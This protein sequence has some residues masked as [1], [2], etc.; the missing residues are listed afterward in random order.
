[1]GFGEVFRKAY[2]QGVSY[3]AFLKADRDRL[4]GRVPGYLLDL[5]ESDGWAGYRD[6]LLWMVD[7]DEFVPVLAAWNVPNDPPLIVVA[8]TA[9]GQLF[10][11]GSN[12]RAPNGAPAPKVLVLNPH[13]ASYNT[14]GLVAEKFLTRSIADEDF[15]KPAMHEAE[16]KRAAK[17]VGPI[18]WNEMYGYEPALALGGSGKA[19]T[20]RRFDLFTHHL[21]LSQLVPLKLRKV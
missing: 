12:F 14:V 6:G 19:D 18:S 7:P 3:R 11:L 5:W 10:L 16:T 17:D 9:M 4:E 13:S 8:R 1:M 15:L 20:V 21:L 2:G